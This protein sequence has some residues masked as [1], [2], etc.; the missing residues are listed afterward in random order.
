[1]ARKNP[2]RTA[3]AKDRVAKGAFQLMVAPAVT[4]MML[5]AGFDFTLIDSEHRAMNPETIENLIRAAHARGSKKGAVVRISGIRRDAFQYALD[6]GAD[7]ILVPLVNTVE[8]AEQSVSYTRFPPQGSRGLNGRSRATDWGNA[9]IPS[10]CKAVNREISL[11]IQIETVE[12]LE[13]VAAIAA[14]P[15]IDIIFVGP[16]DLSHSIGLTG[17][18]G[19]KEVRSAIRSIFKAAKQAGK[20]TGVLA[21][22]TSF[23]NWCIKQGVRFLIYRNDVLFFGAGVKESFGEIAGK[24]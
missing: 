12:A 22:D 6:A 19:H 7:G 18:L 3:L 5:D 14:V 16:Y 13:N 23:A 1:M 15:G 20:A 17:Q 2:I 11:A 4:E 21:P 9:D 8:E 24:L 10:Y